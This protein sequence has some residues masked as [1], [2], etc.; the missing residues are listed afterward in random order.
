MLY[1]FQPNFALRSKMWWVFV[2]GANRKYKSNFREV[3]IVVSVS[4]SA[5]SNDVV[6]NSS[7]IDLQTISFDNA[8]QCFD[9]VGWVF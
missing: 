7:V 9:T 8:L 1:R 5:L 6:C 2:C 3:Q 4:I